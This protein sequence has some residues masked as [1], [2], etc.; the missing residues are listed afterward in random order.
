MKLCRRSQTLRGEEVTI[1]T[2]GSF[3][4][5][6]ALEGGWRWVYCWPDDGG[7]SSHG[8]DA[9]FIGAVRAARAWGYRSGRLSRA[10]RE[11]ARAS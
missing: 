1:I 11:P 10:H 2:D 6:P 3:R 7:P 4:Y 9:T 5:W 8:R